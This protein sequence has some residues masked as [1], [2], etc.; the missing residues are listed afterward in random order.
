M[1]PT[2]SGESSERGDERAAGIDRRTYLAGA[3][4]AG[5]TAAAGCVGSITGG[6]GGGSGPLNVI[7][8]NDYTRVKDQ[9][10]ERVG[11]TINM[12]A[13]TSSTKMF[14]KWNAG[15]A[16]Q[17]DMALPN[18]NL[19]N[20][21]Y[22]A[23]LLQPI[24]TD[25]IPNWSDMYDQFQSLS[26]RQFENQGEMYGVPIRFGWYGLSYD[27]TEVPEEKRTT[28]ET[29]WDDEYKGKV[30]V[31]N[32][33]FKA[34]AMAALQ[35]G[36][37]DAFEGE[38]VTLSD[39]QLQKCKEA[40]VE[41]K[42]LVFGYLSG[43]PSWVKAYKRENVAV[44]WSG[45][46]EIVQLQQDD[47]SRAGT[48]VAKEGGLAW[49]EGAIISKQSENKEAV[50]DLINAMLSPEIGAELAKAGGAPTTTPGIE[51]HL[52]EKQQEMFMVDPSR[53]KSLFPFKPMANE[54]KWI[55]A[56]EDVKDA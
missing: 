48:T 2:D 46:N 49:Y 19:V 51:K 45:R 31:Y 1:A 25:E 16:D 47:V 36:Y 53:M 35:L 40:L 41:Q 32:N 10:E 5:L 30:A 21:F 17:F 24:N 20:K 8:W 28:V 50:Q 55:A 54:Q 43:N 56:W 12:T 13:M 15:G 6:A 18:N 33:H 23:D 44:G 39:K 11:R 34:I 38:K 3:G 37:Q 22:Q 14:S 7:V 29:L 27:K 42:P 4:T 9:L 26:G 52:S